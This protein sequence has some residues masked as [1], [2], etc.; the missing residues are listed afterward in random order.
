MK[1][2]S[3]A[4]YNEFNVSMKNYE[5]WFMSEHNY[6]E[7]SDFKVSSVYFKW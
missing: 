6:H 1:Y 3:I 7:Y 5:I 4:F 2:K